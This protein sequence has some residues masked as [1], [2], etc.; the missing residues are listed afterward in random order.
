MT[1]NWQTWLKARARRGDVAARI[2]SGK[3]GH[4]AWTSAR[5]ID[6]SV[7]LTCDLEWL[8]AELKR[9]HAEFLSRPREWACEESTWATCNNGRVAVRPGAALA[10]HDVVR[11]A[12]DYK[13]A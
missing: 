7:N 10:R 2:L 8:R 3:C 6:R 13:V 12:A 5:W 4:N 9:L 11:L 1:D